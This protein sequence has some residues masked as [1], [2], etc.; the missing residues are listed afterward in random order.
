MMCALQIAAAQ[1]TAELHSLQRKQAMHTSLA[2]Q[3]QRLQHR[4]P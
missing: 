2:W 4:Q 3:Q 1:L